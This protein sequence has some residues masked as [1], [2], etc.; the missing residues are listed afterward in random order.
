MICRCYR[1]EKAI[2]GAGKWVPIKIGRM[3]SEAFVCAECAK[4]MCNGNN[5]R[6]HSVCDPRP[7]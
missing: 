4:V 7:P 6:L 2:H 3:S 1:C 5:Q